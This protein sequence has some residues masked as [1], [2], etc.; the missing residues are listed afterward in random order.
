MN[1]NNSNYKLYLERMDASAA[2][3]SKGLIPT[4]AT[5]RILD[6]GCGSGVLLRQLENAKGIDLNP[7]AVEECKKQGLDADCISLFDLDEKFDTIIFSSVLHEF[8]SYADENRYT[9]IPIENALKQAY[10]NLN[11]GGQ[12]IIRDGIEGK[13]ICATLTAKNEEVVEAFKKYLKDAPM[14]D[15]ANTF[16]VYDGLQIV[17]PIKVLKEFM[18]TYTWGPDSYPREVNEKFGI[19][20]EYRWRETV[21]KAGFDVTYVKTFAEEYADYLSVHFERD[22]T[23][24]FIFNDSTILLIATKL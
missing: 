21:T 10:K 12:I 7:K 4:Y 17:A 6:V 3:S 15:E 20:N 23:L 1:F 9:S 11:K 8:S 13:R 16:V 22:T 18:F 19:L 2:V 5:G 14:W 24:E